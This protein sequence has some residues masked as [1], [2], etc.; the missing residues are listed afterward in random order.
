MNVR[1]VR[2]Y[3]EIEGK[4]LSERIYGPDGCIGNAI[5]LNPEP[6]TDAAMHKLAGH[7]SY[8]APSTNS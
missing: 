1:A 7:S 4:C 8:A 6:C 3:R 2:T 5:I